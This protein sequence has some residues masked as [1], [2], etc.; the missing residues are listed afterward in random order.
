MIKININRA[1]V[2]RKLLVQ[3]KAGNVYLDAVLMT[4]REGTDQYG[5]DGFIV[6][7]VSKQQESQGIKGPIIGNW[8]NLETQ[9][10]KPAPQPQQSTGEPDD[11][12]W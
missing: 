4:N 8:R 10:P 12:A 2:D 1:K 6:Q 9:K 7:W 3:G 5:N 11:Y